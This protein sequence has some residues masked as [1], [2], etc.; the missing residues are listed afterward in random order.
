MALPDESA[1]HPAAAVFLHKVPSPKLSADALLHPVAGLQR[2]A[3]RARWCSDS[4]FASDRAGSET[5]H[6]AR[7]T[8]AQPLSATRSTENQPRESPSTRLRRSD[9]DRC[10]PLAAPA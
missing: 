2:T 1:H 5:R 8:A 4:A 9:G 6:I 10:A 3:N 7:S